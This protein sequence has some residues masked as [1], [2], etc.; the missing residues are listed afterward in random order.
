[1]VVKLE[2]FARTKI[3][4]NLSLLD[5]LNK[6]NGD[7]KNKS[8]FKL[9]V[10]KDNS[11]KLSN[12]KKYLLD[13]IRKHDLLKLNENDNKYYVA[14]VKEDTFEILDLNVDYNDFSV[15]IEFNCDV[16]LYDTRSPFDKKMDYPILP[17]LALLQ[18][19]NPEDYYFYFRKSR[20]TN[21]ED[22]Y[23]YIFHIIKTPID[24]WNSTKRFY[25][26]FDLNKVARL[27]NVISQDMYSTELDQFGVS[28]SLKKVLNT[29]AGKNDFFDDNLII[30]LINFANGL[31]RQKEII[32]NL[33]LN[34]L[35]NSL[36][37]YNSEEEYVINENLYY[38]D[39]KTQLLTNED[40]VNEIDSIILNDKEIEVL[41]KLL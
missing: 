38:A 6:L 30:G 39:I 33:K 36:P 28:N 25:T 24:G 1:M 34:Y 2:K 18:R 26:P 27:A 3:N 8:K 31:T 40:Y 41:Q 23:K 11:I 9:I 15:S 13:N 22:F 17:F 4:V 14:K 5:N 21:M 20:P 35:N 16:V 29:L 12:L 32:S 37:T 7:G 19:T 10:N